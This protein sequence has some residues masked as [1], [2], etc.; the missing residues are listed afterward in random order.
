MLLASNFVSICP[1]TLN[2][3][4]DY[5]CWMRALS[6]KSRSVCFGNTELC[7]LLN[8]LRLFSFILISPISKQLS[9]VFTPS[10]TT[11]FSFDYPRISVSP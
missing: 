10:F 7:H 5:S 2:F 6:A 9:N 8:I 1:K 11:L 4:L 3:I